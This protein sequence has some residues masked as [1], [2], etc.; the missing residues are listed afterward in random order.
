MVD[1]KLTN[2]NNKVVL[3]PNVVANELVLAK[4]A[5]EAPIAQR[6]GLHGSVEACELQGDQ[7]VG[8]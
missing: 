1:M 7:R 8:V 5:T 3:A 2:A 6:R 4:Q